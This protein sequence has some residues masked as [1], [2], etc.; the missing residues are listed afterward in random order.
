LRDES[1]SEQGVVVD[2]QI[3][4]RDESADRSRQLGLDPVL[5]R[6]REHRISQRL[7]HNCPELPLLDPT[8]RHR[9][10]LAATLQHGKLLEPA[11]EETSTKNHECACLQ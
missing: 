6:L 11:A 5:M 10:T 8:N 4:R 9:A 2:E 3:E 7:M 1:T